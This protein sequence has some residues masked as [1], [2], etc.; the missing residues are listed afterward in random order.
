MRASGKDRIETELRSEEAH[1]SITIGWPLVALGLSLLTGYLAHVV[2]RRAHVPR[3]TLRQARRRQPWM[4]SPRFDRK[5]RRRLCGCGAW[6]GIA[7]GIEPR[8]L[9]LGAGLAQGR[10]RCTP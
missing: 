3:V 6:P 4:S 8:L 7:V 1:S 10:T 9:R 2:G 5:G